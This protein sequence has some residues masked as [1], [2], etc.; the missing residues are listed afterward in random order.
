VCRHHLTRRFFAQ[1]FD[2]ARC[3]PPQP[4]GDE[5][6]GREFVEVPEESV[7]VAPMTS[8]ASAKCKNVFDV[9]RVKDL[10]DFDDHGLSSDEDD[11]Q[12]IPAKP[13]DSRP[14]PRTGKKV[15]P[16]FGIDAS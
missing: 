10:E 11:D 16:N 1:V 4:E 15:L 6:P 14:P 2:I 12:A 7:F 8:H 9:D 3:Y 13:L 5:F